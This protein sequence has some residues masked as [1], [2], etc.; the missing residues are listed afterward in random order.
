MNEPAIRLEEQIISLFPG[1][2]TLVCRGW[3]LKPP[4]L[5]TYGY[6]ICA[7]EMRSSLR[8]VPYGFGKLFEWGEKRAG[9]QAVPEKRGR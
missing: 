7:M 4:K 5:N 1:M 2:E 6:R 8:T 9:W 3:I